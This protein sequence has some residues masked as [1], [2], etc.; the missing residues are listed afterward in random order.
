MLISTSWLWL[1]HLET[2]TRINFNIIM[3]TALWNKKQKWFLHWLEKICMPQRP[4]K[5]RSGGRLGDQ[6]FF[7]DALQYGLVLKYQSSC[8][9][10]L[11]YPLSR[12]FT[13]KIV[14]WILVVYSH[15]IWNK[16]S[17][18][19]KHLEANKCEGRSVKRKWSPLLVT[20][21]HLSHH[22]DRKALVTSLVCT[23]QK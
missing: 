19:K 13:R 11:S 20:S 1:P 3:Y 15:N 7:S 18:F 12:S 6:I 9:R 10:I 5:F 14:A 16:F 22:V 2:C 23:V 17:F 8:S 4:R 21:L